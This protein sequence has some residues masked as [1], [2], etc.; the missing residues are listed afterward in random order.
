MVLVNRRPPAASLCWVYG[1]GLGLVAR[2]FLARTG[3]QLVER[4]L[5][6]GKIFGAD[7]REWTEF[8]TFRARAF[9]QIRGEKDVSLRVCATCG[10][11]LYWSRLHRPYLYPAPPPEHPLFESSSLG[12]VM[13]EELFARANLS[14]SMGVY[15]D[16]LK[17][18]DSPRD[19][20]PG[21]Q[22]EFA[23]K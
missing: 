22:K 3:W 11:N 4:E 12:L 10:R 13:S 21:L 8:A 6:L 23:E 1:F 17:V 5:T 15:I 2:S 16:Q 9:G 19:N 14:K 7:G 20:M 18:L